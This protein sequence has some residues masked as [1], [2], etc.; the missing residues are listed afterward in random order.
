MKGYYLGSKRNYLVVDTETSGLRPEEGHEI[1]QIAGIAVNAW[2]LG[3]HH[4]G[5]FIVLLKPQ[6]PEKADTKAIQILGPLWERAL[7]EGIDPK[8]GLQQFHDWAEKVNDGKAGYTKPML[9]GHNIPFDD[10]F[11]QYASREYKVIKD[12]Q[13]PPWDY[14]VVDTWSLMFTLFE[15]DPNV[16][17]FNLD[18]YLE[19]LGMARNSTIGVHDA[20][21]DVE[22]TYKAFVRTMKFFRECRRRM[23]ITV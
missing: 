5:R 7:K 22:L 20:A 15:S 14:H 18:T 23:K 12:D 3:I 13:S 9:T 21:E 10:K 8:V 11:L 2:D 16:F 17:R 19:Q 4:A 6:R 1:I